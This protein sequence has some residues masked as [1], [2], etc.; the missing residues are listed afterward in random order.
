MQKKE[1]KIREYLKRL[2][3]TEVFACLDEKDM[4]GLSFVTI[5]EQVRDFA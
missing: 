4:A 1:E 5:N 3:M 2:N